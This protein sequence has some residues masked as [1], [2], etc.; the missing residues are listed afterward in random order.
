MKRLDIT[1][2]KLRKN[3]FEV[4]VMPDVK[5]AG[6]YIR[7]K[8]TELQ[9]RSVSFGDSMT[10]YATGV[11]D[12]L[13]IQ[14]DYLFIDTFEEGV[15]FKELIERRRQALVCDTF[16]TG[17]NAISLLDGSLHWLDM[18]GNRVAPIAFGPRN[19]ILVAGRNKITD[20]PQ[21]AYLRIKEKAAPS[22]VARHDGMKT[23]CV[24]TGKCSDCASPQRICNERLVLHK[25]YPK[26][27]IV[28]VLIDE[29]LGL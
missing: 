29:E 10:L 3:G 16:L 9:P 20:N 8:I 18:I 15:R 26:G 6:Q 1:A 11:V 5:E 4:V 17:I 28:V 23:P 27:R 21:E 22:N 19:V 2:E 25:C 12:W 13:R 7:C 14:T 24:V